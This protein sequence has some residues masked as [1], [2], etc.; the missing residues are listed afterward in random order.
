MLGLLVVLDP[1]LTAQCLRDIPELRAV[2]YL[3]SLTAAAGVGAICVIRALWPDILG[4]IVHEHFRYF[5][6][7]FFIA[8][9]LNG[10]AAGPLDPTEIVIGIFLLVFLAALLIRPEQKYVG[11]PFNM[12]H[13]ALG[14]CILL[15]IVAQFRPLALLKSPKPFIVFLLLVNCLAREDILRRFLR[16]LVILAMISAVA[17]LIQEAAWFMYQEVLSLVPK[18]RLSRMFEDTPLGPVFRVPGAMISYRTM[19]LY[20]ATALLLILNALLWRDRLLPRG[21]LLLG[22]PLTACALG[23][24]IAKDILIG[25]SLGAVL[26]IVLRRPARV[27]AMALLGLALAAAIALA[28]VVVPGNVDTALDLTRTIPKTEQE[29]IRLDRDSIEGFLHGPYL[30]TG[31]GIGAGARYTAHVLGWPAHNAFILAAAELGIAGLTVYLLIW[32]LVLVRLVVLN[33]AIR[34][35]PYL[36]LARGLLGVFVVLL[37]GSQFEAAYLDI[38]VWSLFAVVEATWLRAGPSA[39]AAA[40]GIA[41]RVDRVGST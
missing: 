22:L 11:T 17:C 14:A 30:W 16:T 37:A 4:R 20:Q 35:G 2:P 41:P 27:M 7:I 1:F 10:I 23:L 32:G 40:S 24:T 12:L 18:D 25:T 38:F 5:P 15:S 39:Q 21:W 3:I 29:R 33:V 6:V 9:Q 36:P 34:D 8:Y 26:L 31:R 28:V 13:V 19:A